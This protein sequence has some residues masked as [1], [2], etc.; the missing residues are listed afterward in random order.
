MVGSIKGFVS[1]V[2]K[3]N[4][5]VV[6]THCFLHRKVPYL[7]QKQYQMTYV[8]KQVFQMVD[9]IKMRPK[10][11]RFFEKICVDMDSRH[12]R[13]ILHTEARWL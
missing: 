10:K 9:F 5:N 11:S 1:L 8:L 6:Q 13:L 12:K 2:L 4:P 3:E 7:F